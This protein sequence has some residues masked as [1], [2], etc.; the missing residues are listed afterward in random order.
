MNRID[1]SSVFDVI[2]IAG[3]TSDHIFTVDLLNESGGHQFRHRAIN[4]SHADIAFRGNCF[5][6]WKAFHFSSGMTQK[7][8]END[9]RLTAQTML[10]QLVRHLEKL[11]LHDTPFAEN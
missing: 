4:C 3:F 8:A 1:A 10:E 7:T 9:D 11:L 5:A 6:R 2:H